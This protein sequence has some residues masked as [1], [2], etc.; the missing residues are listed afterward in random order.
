MGRKAAILVSACLLGE[1][2]RYDGGAKPSAA[3]IALSDRFNLIPVC[4]E[5]LGGLP[6]PRLPAERRGSRV[7]RSDGVD[8]TAAFFAGAEE[9]LRIARERGAVGAILKAKSPSCGSGKIYDGTFSGVLIG[10][11]GVAVEALLRAGIP[12][13]DELADFSALTA[14]TAGRTGSEPKGG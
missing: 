1:R 5:A 13:Y 14:D 6:T 10:G 4:P 12:V 8:V 2:C 9:T 3:V 11:N 7:V